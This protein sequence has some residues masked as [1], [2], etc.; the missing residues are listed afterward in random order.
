[1]RT[2]AS[3]FHCFCRDAEVDKEL[4]LSNDGRT[5]TRVYI[6]WMCSYPKKDQSG[7]CLAVRVFSL[8]HVDG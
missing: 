3:V 5:I 8:A 2:D 6:C 7:T 1:M 4:L